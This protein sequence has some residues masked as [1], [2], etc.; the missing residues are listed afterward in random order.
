MSEFEVKLSTWELFLGELTRNIKPRKEVI[1]EQLKFLV[2][3]KACTENKY[4]AL[5]SVRVMA[6]YEQAINEYLHPPMDFK[7]ANIKAELIHFG[8]LFEGVLEL[9][10][11]SNFNK[12]EITSIKYNSWFP[13]NK[14][15]LVLN[16]DCLAKKQKGGR[17]QNL[18]FNASIM[19]FSEWNKHA[20][21]DSPDFKHYIGL[22]NALRIQRNNVHVNHM[23]EKGAFHEE[24]KLVEIREK[25]DGFVDLVKSTI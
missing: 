7:Q 20:N 13:D 12:E 18:T 11:A 25:W 19:C 10:L 2:D 16:C 21:G 17:Y 6:A 5:V 23:V 9:F 1:L 15:E 8:S 22:M 24:H 3:H 14:C 4:I